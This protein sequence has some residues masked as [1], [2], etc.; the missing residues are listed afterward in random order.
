MGAGIDR[1]ALSRNLRRAATTLEAAD[2][3]S[4][5]VEARMLSRLAYTR[6]QPGYVLD[7]GCGKGA[8]LSH[9]THRYP[10][11]FC[12][13]VDWEMALF[14]AKRTHPF[15]LAS[16]E[17]L[18]FASESFDL[19][20][21]NLLLPWLDDPLALFRE[22]FRILKPGGLCLFSALGTETLADFCA[23]FAD[24]YPHTQCFMRLY[25]LGDGLLASGF[26][27]PVVD[28]EILDV[29]Y[30]NLP[31]FIRE[32][33]AAGAGCVMTN[34]RKTLAGRAFKARLEAHVLDLMQNHPERRLPITFEIIQG[35]A[36]KPA[37]PEGQAIRFH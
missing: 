3:L 13:G 19:V 35:Q 18:P 36:W 34:R 5:E 24:D 29:T 17:Q 9:L 10:D 7:L 23:G 32:L 22:V 37:K 31:A 21:A 20:W 2:F 6:L 28:R 1:A 15:L 14:P 25:E 8:S 27:D 4:R 12:L 11:A 26:A 33:R 30:P 16:A